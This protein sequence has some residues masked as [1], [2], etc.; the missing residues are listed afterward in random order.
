MGDKYRVAII[1]CGKPRSQ[2]G[3]TG[4][5]MA[6][7]HMQGY[8]QTGKCELAAVAD[9]SRENGE[10]FVGRYGGEAAVYVDYG[11]MLAEVRPDV[12]SVCTWPKLHAPMV[13]AAIG[14]GARAVHCEKPMAPTWGEA[15]AMHAA[16]VERD[17]QL[18]FN[19][20][21]RFLASFQ[22]ARQL[23][24]E[25]AIGP[26]TRIEGSCDNMIDW[27]THWL[28]MFFFYNGETPAEWVLGQID[29]RTE[30]SVFGL[31]ME[32]Q[33]LCEVKFTNGVRGLLFTGFDADIGCANRLVGRDGVIELH[34]E[35]PHVRVRAKG[36]GDWQGHETAEGLHGDVAIDRGVA[37]L[38]ECLE[39]G[40]EPELSSHKAI[41]CTEVIFAT[42]ESSRRR[43]RIDLPLETEDS[44]L[45]S[46]L[47]EGEIGPARS[48]G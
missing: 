46:M 32:S 20:Q 37:D 42:Y 17:V 11:Q 21:R 31:A 14:A 18:T 3:S 23:L 19:H 6:H 40:Q 12:V 15:R 7:L 39:S 5:G 2:E 35:Q 44:A 1:G 4:F 16:A 29:A 10:D 30:R 9:I 38:I 41:R 33:G 27:G 8:L 26:L 47:A 25:G 43:G 24:R 36:V 28:D 34:N 48:A 45:L 22:R 13:L